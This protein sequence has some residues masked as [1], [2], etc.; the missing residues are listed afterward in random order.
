VSL[1][2]DA[3]PRQLESAVEIG[4][5]V[6]EIHTG[7]Y[8]DALGPAASNRALERIVNAVRLGRELELQV[9]AGHG[10]DY[11]NIKAVA[12]V[13]GIIEFNIGHAIISQ[14]VFSGLQTAVADMKHLLNPV[15]G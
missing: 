14:A 10:L 4:A 6:V 1:F 8:A 7:H 2:I 12:A 13:D 9:N 3:D 11:H 5:P 15:S